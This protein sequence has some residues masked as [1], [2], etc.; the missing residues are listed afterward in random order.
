VAARTD[1]TPE[2]IAD[3]QAL[4]DEG[5]SLKNV[6]QAMK[7]K[8]RGLAIS[9]PVVARV[10]RPGQIRGRHEGQLK[11][12]D[13]QVTEARALYDSGLSMQ[14]VADH[15][16]DEYGLTV[17]W[18]TIRNHLSKKQIRTSAGAHPKISEKD[19]QKLRQLRK[20]DPVKWT[21]GELAYAFGISESL[22]HRIV[23]KK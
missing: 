12:T 22:A 2:Q 5:L 14:Q 16:F 21:Y 9:A 18:G 10:L 4:Y 23:N 20:Q 1:L 15:F 11:L 6:A 17:S 7:K 3:A 8:H 19:K 13:D